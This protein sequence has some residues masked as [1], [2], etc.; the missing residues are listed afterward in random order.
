[1]RGGRG[2][3]GGASFWA[4]RGDTSQIYETVVEEPQKLF[5]K[6]LVPG[7]EFPRS[8]APVDQSVTAAQTIEEELIRLQQETTTYRL[9]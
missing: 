8:L 6:M 3:R 9:Y 5:P 2:G 4:G 7:G 1:M